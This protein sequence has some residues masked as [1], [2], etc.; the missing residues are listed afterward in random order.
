[1][2]QADVIVVG[3]GPAGSAS[4][5]HLAHA[6]L[7]VLL[8]DKAQFPREKVCGDGLTPRA[9]KELSSLGIDV[10]ALE[11]K[12]NR[13]LRIHVGSTHY[14]M[15]WPELTGFPNFGMA[16]QRS[17]FDQYLVDVACKSGVEFVSQANVDS[18]IRRKDRIAGV[19]T[20]DGRRFEAPVVVAAD[21][22]SARLPIAMGLHRDQ[23][24]PLGV[25]VRTYFNSPLSDAD[26]LDS[27]LELW[28]GPPRRSRLLPGYGWSFPI[29]DGACNVGLGLPD[30]NRY[31]HVNLRQMMSNWLATMPVE[32]G[33]TEPNRLTPIVSAALPMGFNRQPL[34]TR[35]LLLVGDSAGMINAFNGEGISYAMES[36]R[37][38]ADKIAQAHTRGFHTR[39]ADQ[40]LRAYPD[41]LTQQ[42]S[43]YF[44]LGNLF[45]KIIA[46]PTVM[47]TASHYGLP[48][49]FVRN[50]T[51]RMLAHLWDQPPKTLYDHLC[52]LLTHLGCSDRLQTG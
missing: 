29:G 5:I 25:A 28:E 47:K 24:R 8:L 37:Y 32:W 41:F 12:R 38:A 15:A 33:L 31:R 14:L 20:R 34:Y 43:G 26:W 11:W 48:I 23:S 52:H 6:G 40:I 22:N 30:A 42:W 18:P 13:G 16:I 50:L 1:M 17:V 36:A 45:T 9:V 19:I 49:P 21:G 46:H 2:N 35:G 4:A 44:R 39:A 3:A 10:Q 51:H 7:S 27:W